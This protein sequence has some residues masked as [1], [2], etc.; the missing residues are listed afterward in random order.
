MR[1]E[2]GQRKKAG[3]SQ[4]AKAVRNQPESSRGIPAKGTAAEHL[5]EWTEAGERAGIPIEAE[6]DLES[7]IKPGLTGF[8]DSEPRLDPDSEQGATGQAFDLDEA[9][10][11]NSIWMRNSSLDMGA[12]TRMPSHKVNLGGRRVGG[13]TGGDFI[14]GGGGPAIGSTHEP[15]EDALKIGSPEETLAA[16]ENKIANENIRQLRNM[17]PD[18]P[19][20]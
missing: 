13:P 5:L 14:G 2:P 12:E 15:D 8:S 11:G 3:K 18:K 20:G 6:P 9:G 10:S 4:G 1:D 19:A 7:P 16:F 17:K